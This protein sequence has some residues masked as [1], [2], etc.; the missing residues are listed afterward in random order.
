MVYVVE[1][2]LVSFD[3]LTNGAFTQQT[4]VRIDGSLDNALNYHHPPPLHEQAAYSFPV[5]ASIVRNIN[6]LVSVCLIYFSKILAFICFD[7]F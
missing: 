7:Y 6:A 5:M 1:C 2:S 3:I 4:R